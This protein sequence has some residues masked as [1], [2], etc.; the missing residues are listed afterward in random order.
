MMM[1]SAKKCVS[2]TTLCFLITLLSFCY[3]G[4]KEQLK[5]T[6]PDQS[7]TAMSSENQPKLTIDSVK[8]DAGE[9]YEGNK[10][11]HT[12]T[13]KNVGTAQL[14]I[15]AVKA[16]WGCTVAKFDEAILPGQEGKVTLHVNTK[17]RKG[18]VTQSATI[19][20]DDPN[21]PQI[22]IYLSGTIKQIISIEPSFRLRFKGYAGDKISKT[23]TITSHEEQ[24]LK[25]TEITSDVSD[26][27]Q[28]E[29]KTLQEGKKYSLDIKT[30]TGIK[31]T[32][33]GKI[34]LVTNSK[35]N[36]NLRSLWQANCSRKL[37]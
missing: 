19:I 30:I 10:I 32:F 25:I 28:Y 34:V 23:V 27:I 2:I 14:N 22:K 15:K 35:K 13:I 6:A 29:L 36:L 16:G 21:N 26:Q 24:P 20:S 37:R 5:E 1:F 33:Q 11:M 9:V 12:Y 3:L 17:N 31:E 18:K 8:Y 4:A 7:N